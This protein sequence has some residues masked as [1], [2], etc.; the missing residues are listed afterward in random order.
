[1]L[2]VSMCVYDKIGRCFW[3]KWL[4]RTALL[5]KNR[6]TSILGGWCQGWYSDD[7]FVCMCC[8]FSVANFGA[9]FMTKLGCQMI[10]PILAI[11]WAEL[12]P[13][14]ASSSM[15]YS[16]MWS[17]F[18]KID[19]SFRRK[20]NFTLGKGKIVVFK[21]SSILFEFV[22]NQYQIHFYLVSSEYLP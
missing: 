5:I 9:V 6:G 13:L 22:N 18:C 2:L 10:S 21:G 7:F 4:W 15:N 20:A 17:F 8:A 12:A 16:S 11:K 19:K 1:M 3:C 14:I